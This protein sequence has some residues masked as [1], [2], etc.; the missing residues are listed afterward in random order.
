MRDLEHIPYFRFILAREFEN[1]VKIK[2]T[3]LTVLSSYESGSFL[4][5]FNEEYMDEDDLIKLSTAISYL[6]GNS[7]IDPVS[8]MYYATFTVKHNDALQR[9]PSLLR[10]YE[11][12][13]MHTDGAYL[14]EVPDWIFFM[15]M[16]EVGAIGGESKLLHIDDWGDFDHFYN[17]PINK[18]KIKF[19]ANPDSNKTIDRHTNHEEIILYTRQC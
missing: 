7:N 10:A 15:K 14:K 12:F 18:N 19:F 13:K 9:S 2:N 3:M 6:L 5:N 1:T 4:V 16:E 8:G 17:H 11:D